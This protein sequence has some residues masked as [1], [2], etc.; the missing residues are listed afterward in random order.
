MKSLLAALPVAAMPIAAMLLAV[1]PSIGMAQSPPT[2]DVTLADG[3]VLQGQIDDATDD[4]HLWL[5]RTE[6][7]L[8]LATSYAWKSVERIDV[9]GRS[10]DKKGILANVQKWVAPWPEQFL[11]EGYEDHLQPPVNQQAAQWVPSRP[12]SVAFEA[13]LANWDAD[14]EPDGYEIAVT[15]LDDLGQPVPVRGTLSAKLVG[16]R[17][18]RRQQPVPNVELERWSERVDL[19]DFSGGPAIYRLP[20]RRTHPEIELDIAPGA[21]LQVEV[22]AFGQGRFAAS[23]SVPVRPF[24]PVRDRLQQQTGSRFFRGERSQRP[25]R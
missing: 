18:D 4:S 9:E 15:M 14:V 23:T 12:V 17:I 7:R 5:R 19:A 22:G 25:T 10:Y 21:I 24:S 20:F 13:V 6:N 16:E 1:S 2:A 8:V 11:R 3:R